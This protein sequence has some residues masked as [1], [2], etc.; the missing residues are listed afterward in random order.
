MGAEHAAK[1][2][3]SDI[4][5]LFAARAVRGFGDGFAIIILPA[6][7]TAIGY[8]PFQ[9]GVVA[10]LSLLGSAFLTLAAGFIAPRHDLRTLL[11]SGAILMIATGLGFAN[12]EQFPLI[13]FVAFIG[14]VNAS[15]GDIGMLVPLEH[16][17]LARSVADAERTRGFARY[18]LIGTLATAA[19]AL[20]AAGPDLLVSA[21]ITA[22]DALRWKVKRALATAILSLDMGSRP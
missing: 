15:A 16:A 14:T 11:L 3:R 1:L 8:S 7:L 10:A 9:I 18:S 19:G 12:V 4:L 2:P 17:M 22:A 20:A 5:L 13:C 21:G 6:Y